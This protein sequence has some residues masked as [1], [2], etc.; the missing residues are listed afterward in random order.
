MSPKTF[1]IFHYSFQFQIPKTTERK[2][3]REAVAFSGETTLL[4]TDSPIIGCF[5]LW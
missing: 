1:F 4:R 3:R 5:I 2:R